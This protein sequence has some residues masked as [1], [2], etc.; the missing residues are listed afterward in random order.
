M[1]GAGDMID[2]DVERFAKVVAEL[3]TTSDRLEPTMTVAAEMLVSEVHDFWMSAGGGT[4]PA[5]APATLEKRRGSI[6]QILIDTGRGIGSLQASSGP[7]FAEAATDVDYMRYHCGD[8]ARTV[9]PKRDPFD[10][11]EVATARV[12]EYVLA[13]YVLKWA[14]GGS[15]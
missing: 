4:W 9:I 12:V 10:L 14:A 11:P 15:K 13:D 3:G 1:P 6:A 5:L 8:G 2:L 7:D